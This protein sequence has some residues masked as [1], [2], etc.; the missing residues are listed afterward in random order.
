MKCDA[1][2]A[3]KYRRFAARARME[4]DW[5][6]ANAFQET[7]ERDRTEHFCKEAELAG[8]IGNSAE[9]LRNAIDEESE[10]TL[11]FARFAQ[12]AKE[13]GDLAIGSLFEAISRDKAARRAKFESILAEMGIHSNMHAVSLPC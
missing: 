12:Q 4:E 8:L 3:A 11:M 13:E 10:E 5:Q 7:A 2:D 1:L 9:N 6:L